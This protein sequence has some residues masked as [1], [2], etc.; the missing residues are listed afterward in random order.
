VLDLLS[1]GLSNADIAG[2][3]FI[4]AKTVHHHVGRILFKLGLRNRAGAVAW[5]LRSARSGK[6]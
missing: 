3:L 2:R 1:H 4:S 5:T 6:K